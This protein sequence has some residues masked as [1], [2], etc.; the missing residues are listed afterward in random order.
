[1]IDIVEIRNSLLHLFGKIEWNEERKQWVWKPIL[2]NENNPP[3]PLAL[4][5]NDKSTGTSIALPDFVNNASSFEE[6]L[7]CYGVDICDDT[8]TLDETKPVLGKYVIKGDLE[9]NGKILCDSVPSGGI[10]TTDFSHEP[11]YPVYTLTNDKLSI[12]TFQLFD[13]DFKMLVIGNTDDIQ[14]KISNTT[15]RTN[16]FKVILRKTIIKNAEGDIIN[17]FYIYVHDGKIYNPILMHNTEHDETRLS[18]FHEATNKIFIAYE[19]RVNLDPYNLYIKGELSIMYLLPQDSLVAVEPTIKCDIIDAKNV[20]KLHESDIIYLYRP[21]N[22]SDETLDGHDYY[23]MVYKIPNTYTIPDGLNFTFKDYSFSNDWSLI[24]NATNG[25]WEGYNCS[26]HV[27]EKVINKLNKRCPKNKLNSVGCYVM[28]K[29]D[30]HNTDIIPA[31]EHGLMYSLANLDRTETYISYKDGSLKNGKDVEVS[32][33]IHS[34]ENEFKYDGYDTLKVYLKWNKYL[35]NAIYLHSIS[36]FYWD[37]YI[38]NSNIATRLTFKL[39]PDYKI[40]HYIAYDYTYI[41]IIG[42]KDTIEKLNINWRKDKINTETRDIELYLRKAM[43]ESIEEIKWNGNTNPFDYIIQSQFYEITPRPDAATTLYTDYNITS[44]KIITADNITTM[45]SDVNVLTNNFDVLSYDF[46]ILRIDVNKLQ[47]EML[48]QQMITKHLSS[49]VHALIVGQEISLLF[50]LVGFMVGVGGVIVDNMGINFGT[51][52]IYNG[53][54]V[55]HYASLDDFTVDYGSVAEDAIRLESGGSIQ[56][57]VPSISNANLR[58]NEYWLQWRDLLFD[59]DMADGNIAMS[60]YIFQQIVDLEEI[61]HAEFP[62]AEMPD[63]LKVLMRAKDLPTSR[64]ARSTTTEPDLI[65]NVIEWCEKD[66]QRLD[67]P[68]KFKDNWINPDKAVLSLSATIDIC[69]RM[70][71]SM[72]LP[73]GILAHEIQSI[74]EKLSNKNPLEEIDMTAYVTKA[75]VK[76][77]LQQKDA[78]IESLANRIAALEKKCANIE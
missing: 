19:E 68:T 36:R 38:P 52:A 33:E 29:K 35:D 39:D 11:G 24:W 34:C 23:K 60:D 61:I 30:D 10:V 7:K 43:T 62:L 44:S 53:N 42:E 55:S 54:D 5:S 12:D 66:Y 47:I 13:R 67:D 76:E 70:R 50:S 48:A 56:R 27:K 6:V 49:Q 51:R 2:E 8:P 45:R 57:V 59:L 31:N 75:E 46:N 28:I 78:I 9:V 1:M 69:N 25:Q 14:K 64:V 71:D 73:I 3:S 63:W 17:E 65:T 20:M 77:M 32:F 37:L 72:K 21:S 74:K 4:L 15:E 18:Y 41:D 22:I 16:I 40:R 26:G 58:L